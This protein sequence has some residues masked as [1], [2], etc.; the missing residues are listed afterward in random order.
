M[1]KIHFLDEED[2]VEGL[3]SLEEILL[4]WQTREKTITILNE[5]KKMR[6]WKTSV[7]SAAKATFKSCQETLVKER[8]LTWICHGY[9]T[10]RNCEILACRNFKEFSG[11]LK[12]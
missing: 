8:E 11:K 6:L 7:S 3:H 10:H 5:T 9:V 4:S 1:S 12:I 2:L